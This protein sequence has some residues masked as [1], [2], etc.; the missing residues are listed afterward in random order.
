MKCYLDLII[1]CI[2]TIKWNIR[3]ESTFYGEN[4]LIYGIVAICI[5]LYNTRN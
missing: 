4:F 1:N 3:E 2:L 5:S